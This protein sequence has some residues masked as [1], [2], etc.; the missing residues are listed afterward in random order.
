MATIKKRV[1]PAPRSKATAKGAALRSAILDVAARLFI[2]RGFGST[3]IR[4]IADAL[5]VTRTAVYYYFRSKDDILVTF[6]ERILRASKD[7]TTQLATRTDLDP[8]EALRRLVEHHAGL[9]LSRPL[10]FRVGDRDERHLPSKHRA[11]IRAAR[12]AVLDNFAQVITRGIRL[13]RLRA[14]DARVAAFSLIGMCSWA[15]WWYQPGGRLSATEIAAIVADLA[16]HSLK[17]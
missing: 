11:A 8:E 17:R 3:N 1:A 12:R 15:A 9:I 4:D 2:E 5:G 13:R 7:F 6:S 14:V 10:E 16:V